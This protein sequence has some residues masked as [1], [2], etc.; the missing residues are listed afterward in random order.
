[1]GPLKGIRVLDLSQVLAGPFGA[2]ML[3]DLGADV[4]KIEP[5]HGD[6]TRNV[7]GV[8]R[9]GVPVGII[10]YNRS[11]RGIVIDFKK[12]A[13]AEVFLRMAEKAQV[14]VQNFR[15]GVVDKLGVGYQA[16]SQ[17]NPRIVYCSMAG[18]GFSG[19][20]V[21][22]PAYDPIIQGRAGAME[23]QRTQGRPRVIKNAIADKIT[24]M[25]A[26]FS[27]VSA[28]L[29]VGENGTGQHI[30]IAMIDALAYFLLSDTMIHQ[31]FLPHKPGIRPPVTTA[32]PFATA[33]GFITIA[34]LTDKHWTALLKA[35]GHPEWFEGDEPRIERAKRS[36]R[37]L[38]ELFQTKPS[39]YW[40]PLIEQADVPCGRLNT[41]DSIFEDPQ[42]VANKTFFEYE[43]P[44][45]GLVRGVRVPSRFSVTEPELLHHAP[46]LGGST[47]EILAEYG[48]SGGEISHLR[49]ER[50]VS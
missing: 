32:E 17:R 40:L 35:V 14:V 21:D 2:M 33:D 44:R 50:I 7:P 45:A 28:L 15:P 1:M 43:H 20:D 11:K 46:D 31:T 3:G 22:K 4:I 9:N 26:A 37:N 8:E 5:P 38:I 27:I 34:P 41:Y 39:E 29:A 25:T 30:Q 19:P 48:F 23:S 42:F 6:V 47:D 36:G 24:G 18:Y 49:A 10:N 16:T 13:G 12:P